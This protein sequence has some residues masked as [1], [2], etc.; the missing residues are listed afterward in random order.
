MPPI[1][2]SPPKGPLQVLCCTARPKAFSRTAPVER[3]VTMGN[4]ETT[5]TFS[6]TNFFMTFLAWLEL[7]D[8][9]SRLTRRLPAMRHLLEH[10]ARDSSYA[11]NSNHRI[12]SY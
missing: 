3:V 2:W 10:R 7:Q 4:S 11:S 9:W 5:S 12:M 6:S 8:F 1:S